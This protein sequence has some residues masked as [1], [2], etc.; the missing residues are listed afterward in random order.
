M[1]TEVPASAAGS[2]ADA[3]ARAAA[4]SRALTD[5]LAA[6]RE[7]AG[8]ASSAG[9]AARTPEPAA[10]AAEASAHGPR[11]VV[12]A[13]GGMAGAG[14]DATQRAHTASL[15]R[16]FTERTRASKELAQHHRSALA[17]SRA[18][19]GFRDA[20][21]EM[22]Y[23]IAAR[24]AHGSRL[25]DVDGND[26]TDITMGF[27]ALLLG[28]EAAPVTEAVRRHLADGLRF[29]PRSPD[30]G[31]AAALLASLTGTERVAFASSGTEANSAAIRLARAA[32]GRDKVVM[33]RGSYHGHID[34]VL[35]AP[36]ARGSTPCP[37]RGA[38]R[39]VRWRS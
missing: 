3:V 21:K 17:D 34:S 23:P 35:A 32:T 9:A 31:E 12:D 30:T 37:S 25:T 16:R 29:G 1:S 19:V 2:A 18:V 11:L 26:Y 24:S 13:A 8:R 27:G 4:L 15:V 14:A 36:A 28:H 33:F 5:R 20:T 22:L 6:A 39:P 7:A 38:S 10:P